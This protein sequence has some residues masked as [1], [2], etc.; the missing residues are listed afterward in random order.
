MADGTGARLVAQVGLKVRP[1]FCRRESRQFAVLGAGRA[2]EGFLERQARSTLR[3]VVRR[4]DLIDGYFASG[5]DL[6]FLELVD[7]GLEALATDAS[8]LGGA[9]VLA[10]DDELLVDD[11]LAREHHKLIGVVRVHL[12]H[13][14]VCRRRIAFKVI[15][16][17]PDVGAQKGPNLLRVLAGPGLVGDEHGI[18]I[19][20]SVPRVEVLGGLG[21]AL[22]DKVG[23]RDVVAL[24]DEVLV[25]DKVRDRKV[26][27]DELKIDALLFL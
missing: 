27:G 1:M 16:P 22:G 7:L 8:D 9:A 20:A 12:L 26:E 11:H 2:K 5:K 6:E 10:A 24:L 14:C 17:A 15:L 18:G 19:K 23:L 13:E 21:S 4:H 3:Q 25:R